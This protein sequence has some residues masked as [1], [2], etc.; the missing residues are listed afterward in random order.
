MDPLIPHRRTRIVD[1]AVMP[2]NEIIEIAKKQ[3]NSIREKSNRITMLEELVEQL[4][5]QPP[6]ESE[7]LQQNSSDSSMGSVQPLPSEPRSELKLQQAMEEERLVYATELSRHE[8]HIQELQQQLTEKTLELTELQEKV[9]VWREKVMITS[10]Q[11]QKTIAE[12]QEQ[13]EKYRV[14]SGVTGTSLLSGM[15]PPEVLESAVQEKLS[16]WKERVKAKMQE[17]MDRIEQL[18]N[19]LQSLRAPMFTP[20][21]TATQTNISDIKENELKETH[22]DP[23]SRSSH[24]QATEETIEKAVEERVA[25]WKKRVQETIEEDRRVIR[26]LQEQLDELR[27]NSRESNI[28]LEAPSEVV[29]NIGIAAISQVNELQNQMLASQQQH[30]VVMQSLREEVER[31]QEQ[32]AAA[33]REHEEAAAALEA[34]QLDAAQS[35]D[36]TIATL[37][38]EV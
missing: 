25:K 9:R 8:G 15:I 14:S 24:I 13:L 34:H 31:L 28:S 17:D 22:M 27:S 21:T 30:K 26:Q 32:L 10:Q 12:L 29:T 33:Q 16:V 23:Q 2:R 35:R 19:E 6:P 4:T 1:L 20:S 36:E 7:T 38:Q 37:S 3:A 18:E 5:G 11:D